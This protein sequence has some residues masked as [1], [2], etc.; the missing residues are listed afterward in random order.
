[1]RAELDKQDRKAF[2]RLAF[3][4][5][6]WSTGGSVTVEST[7]EEPDGKVIGTVSMTFKPAK[8]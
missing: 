2:A 6:L 4:L 5:A 8:P 3:N 7:L 1:M